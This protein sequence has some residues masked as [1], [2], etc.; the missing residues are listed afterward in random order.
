[1][2]LKIQLKMTF[3]QFKISVFLMLVTGVVTAQKYDKKFNENFKTN[4]DVVVNINATNAT[5]DVTTWN[6]NEVFVEAVIEIEGLGKSEA[7]K[8]LNKWKFEALGNKSKV[9]INAT[10]SNMHSLGNDNIVFFNPS[11]NSAP[12]VYHYSKDANDVIVLPEL[13][14]IIIPEIDEIEIPEINFEELITG[15]DYIEFDFD[16]YA[17]DGKNYFFQWKDGVNNVTIKSKKEWEVFK[18][19]KKYK[20]FKKAQEKNKKALKEKFKQLEREK[21]IE[22]IKLKR[23]VLKKQENAKKQQL[24]KKREMQ[25]MALELKREALINARKQLSEVS[26]SRSFSNNGNNLIING[27]KVKVT[28]KVTI[29]VPKNATFDLN[30]RH[31]KIKLPKTKASGKV[32]YGTFKAD[33]LSGGELNISY[34]PVI[35]NSLNTTDLFLNNVTDAH[36]ASV[37][38]TKI[39]STSSE[40][41]LV[42]VYK[43]VEVNSEFG[44]LKINKIHQNYHTFKVDLNS[45]E[46]LINIANINKKLAHVIEDKSRNHPHKPAIKFS[47][48]D[49]KKEV[50]GNFSI[51][52]EDNMLKIIGKYS[53]LVLQK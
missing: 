50:N 22:L 12:N 7:Q 49:S 28:K 15:L 5:I 40:V 53:Q 44:G 32:S 42:N 4:N 2:N 1:M 27:K 41:V 23:E 36:I 6:K 52:T 9:K 39:S 10:N 33:V 20:K 16:K 51:S 45:S 25:R 18:K 46:A 37:A 35:I 19:T 3:K 34:S 26:Y 48:N 24:I 13:P 17:K 38:N 47:I 29:K 30:T 8:Y 14:T 11:K 43:N 21:K 31:C